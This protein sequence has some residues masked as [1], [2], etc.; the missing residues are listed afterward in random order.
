[1]NNP[2]TGTNWA[3]E[4]QNAPSP[5]AASLL[6][7]R[8]FQLNSVEETRK[9]HLETLELQNQYL[10]ENLEMMK[11]NYT[12]LEALC[13]LIK[14]KTNQSNEKENTPLSPP[15]KKPRRSSRLAKKAK[16]RYQ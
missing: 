1:M 4:K 6:V 11:R 13:G 10:K 7:T 16:K 14:L 5:S 3:I 12:L 15:L 2:E 9:K 8:Q